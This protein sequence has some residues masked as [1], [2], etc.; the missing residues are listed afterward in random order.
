MKDNAAGAII[1]GLRTVTKDWAKQRKAEERDHARRFKRHYYLTRSREPNLKEIAAEV[2]E[3]A[4]LKAS[5]N[6]QY[7]ANA[8]QIMYAARPL[9]EERS[10]EHLNDQ[11]FTQTLLPDY[12]AEHPELDWDV[13]YDARGHFREPHTG[14]VVDLG[15]LNVRDYLEKLRAPELEEAGLSLAEVSTLGPDCRFS[16]IMFIEKEGFD[17]I[18]RAAQ[19]ARRYDIG[20]MST[21]GLSVTAARHL[22][23]QVCGKYEIPLLVLH[24]FDKAGFS[25]LGTLSYSN[26]RYAFRHEIKIIDF[27]LRLA[28]IREF[29]LEDQYELTHDRGDEESRRCNLRWN[30]ATEEEIDILLTRRVELNSMTSDQLVAFIEAKLK[31]HGIKKIVAGKEQLEEAYQLFAHAAHIEEVVNEA[32]ENIEPEDVKA[33]R[34]LERKVR[35]YLKQHPEE[36]WDHAV[37]EIA[38][39]T[40]EDDN[41]DDDDADP[42]D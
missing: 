5:G 18:L 41:D 2:M 34:G 42:A 14:R 40:V 19:I 1:A 15:T 28:D 29:D 25:I 17:A 26:R 10:G 24:D 39:A 27:G 13:A 16:A 32:L 30:G 36:R 4:Y 23:D 9:I 21:K 8:R 3:Q 37:A 20:I 38:G 31:K 22:V 6:G 35:E 7:P 12:L 33:P 11:Y